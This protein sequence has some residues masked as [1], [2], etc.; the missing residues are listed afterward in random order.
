MG[1]RTDADRLQKF[2]ESAAE[3]AESGLKAYNT[4]MSNY[5]SATNRIASEWEENFK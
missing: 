5:N 1:L 4:L 3:R 2:N